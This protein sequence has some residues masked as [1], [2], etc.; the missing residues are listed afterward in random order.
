MLFF[1]P[2]LPGS[3]FPIRSANDEKRIDSEAL[4]P[5]LRIVLDIDEN[6]L[7]LLLIISVM[8]DRAEDSFDH[9]LGLVHTRL[10]NNAPNVFLI[11]RSEARI[12]ALAKML[13]ITS[14]VFCHE[15]IA[16]EARKMICRF[17]SHSKVWNLMKY[18]L[19]EDDYLAILSENNEN[20]IAVVVLT[21]HI[22]VAALRKQADH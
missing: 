6:S 18:L 10:P 21:E 19:S 20:W 14:V 4:G 22:I 3:A 7:T 5:P 16:A 1:P 15:R 9:F 11:D 12:V 13:P 8:K 2:V 17:S